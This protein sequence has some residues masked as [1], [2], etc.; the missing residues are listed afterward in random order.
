MDKNT[1]KDSN[2][3]TS[4]AET[5]EFV[6]ERRMNL[7][8]IFFTRLRKSILEMFIVGILGLILYLVF[9]GV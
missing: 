1:E 9:K 5:G 6:N 2:L 8:R 7:S 4:S 3:D